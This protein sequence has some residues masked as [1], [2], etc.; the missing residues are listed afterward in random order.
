MKTRIIHTKIWE[1][2]WFTILSKEAKFLFLYLI[3]NQRINLCGAYEIT[4]RVIMFETGFKAAELQ[5]AKK[6]LVQ[7]II[8]YE[9]WVYVKNAKRHG[10]YKGEKNDLAIERE[11]SVLPEK[12]KKCFIEGKCDRVSLEYPY[13]MDTTRNHKS[14]I[15]NN[16]SEIKEEKIEKISDEEKQSELEK[17]FTITE[18]QIKKLESEYPTVEVRFEYKKAKNHL[19]ANGGMR[20]K[21]ENKPVKD[22]MAYLRL[23]LARDWV[24]KKPIVPVYREPEKHEVSEEGL[25]KFR[26]MKSKLGFKIKK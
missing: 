13:P 18:E 16:K 15:I 3:S 24:K 9:G 7:K 19:L 26:E 25:A 5:K 17:K 8:F 14:E 2:D 1:D 6:E 10:G 21:S 11:L 12:I 20:G 23:W 4:D 22:Y